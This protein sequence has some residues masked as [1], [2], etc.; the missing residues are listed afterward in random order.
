MAKVQTELPGTERPSIEP[1]DEATS[2]YLQARDE[3]NRWKR[4]KADARA[5]LEAEMEEHGDNLER[6]IGGALVYDFYDGETQHQV[7]LETKRKLKVHTKP[8]PA[9]ANDNEGDGKSELT[10]DDVDD[11]YAE[12]FG[13]DDFDDD[14]FDPPPSQGMGQPEQ[15]LG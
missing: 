15:T 2:D 7:V 4:K 14:D 5:H 3:Y 13:D 6:D 8:A 9:S 12:A 1:L 11:A 10:E